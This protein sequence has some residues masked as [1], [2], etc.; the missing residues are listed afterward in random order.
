MRF[1]SLAQELTVNQDKIVA[2]LNSAQGGV[3]D[4]GGYYHPDAEATSKVMRPS[5]ILNEALASI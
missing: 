5:T 1:K 3:V 2:E 4:I